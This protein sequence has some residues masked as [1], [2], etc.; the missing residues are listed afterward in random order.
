MSSHVSQI[1]AVRAG[2]YECQSGANVTVTNARCN[3][4]IPAGGDASSGFQ[5]SR[6]SSDAAPTAFTLNRAAYT[7]G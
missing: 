7:T 2:D 1:T 3:A 4:T 6:T 5:G